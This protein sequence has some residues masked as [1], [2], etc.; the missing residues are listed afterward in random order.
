MYKISV[1]IVPERIKQS[2]LRWKKSRTEEIE[3]MYKEKWMRFVQSRD[4]WKRHSSSSG[5]KWWWWIH[6]HFNRYL[7]QF[8]RLDQTLC[9]TWSLPV[10]DQTWW[11]YICIYPYKSHDHNSLITYCV[12]LHVVNGWTVQNAITHLHLS[13]QLESRVYNDPLKRHVQC[14]WMIIIKQKNLQYTHYKTAYSPSR[15]NFSISVWETVL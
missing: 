5:C 12:K 10:S 15:S 2:T 3:K 8:F 4:E 9:Q 11:K 6:Y 14:C 7:Y 13:G 1:R